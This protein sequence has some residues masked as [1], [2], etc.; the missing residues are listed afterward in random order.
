M[1]T[2]KS[3][4][5]RSLKKLILL[6]FLLIAFSAV[7]K[8][9]LFTLYTSIIHLMNYKYTAYNKN[10]SNIGEGIVESNSYK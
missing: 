2:K 9:S 1:D 10:S 8:L 4:I 7:E 6:Y 3:T 5:V